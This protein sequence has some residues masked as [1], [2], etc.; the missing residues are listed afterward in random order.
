MAQ[1]IERTLQV[2][3]DR[4]LN[5]GGT[6]LAQ[7]ALVSG[8]ID[9]F[10]EYTGTAL[11][12][13]LKKAPESSAAAVFE[14]VSSEYSR[15]FK[16]TWLRPLGFNNTFAMVIRKSDSQ[17]GIATLSAAAGRP[18]KLGVGYEFLQRPDGFQGLVKTY[19][20]KTE[21]SPITMDL[22]LLY[23]ALNNKQVDM[24]AANATDG[25]LSVLDV[26]ILKDDR[27]Y[28]P[29]YECSAVV[30]DE[31]LA[32]FP[33]LRGSIEQLSGRMPDEVMRRLNYAVDGQHRPL[34]EVAREF[35]DTNLKAAP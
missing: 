29:P 14:R 15:R 24:V 3:V 23:T 8:A 26:V 28:F 19:G 5:L 21:G 22:G 18:W 4:R 6:L 25:L 32:R 30:R 33:G 34:R 13:V 31:T 10:P 35:L 20:L 12:T 2:R 7:Q 16:A 9:L 27:K 1:Q 11:T 17:G